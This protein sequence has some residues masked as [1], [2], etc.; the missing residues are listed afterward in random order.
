MDPEAP[1]AD[2]ARRAFAFDR[3]YPPDATQTQARPGLQD[4]RYG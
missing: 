1:R 4:D 3:V 2:A